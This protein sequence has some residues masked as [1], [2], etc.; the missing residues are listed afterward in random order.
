MSFIFGRKSYFFLF[1]YVL[2]FARHALSW[3]GVEHL[4]RR[5]AAFLWV[6]VSISSLALMLVHED[7]FFLCPPAIVLSMYGI[8]ER[9][10]RIMS[11]F[12]PLLYLLTLVALFGFLAVHRGNSEIVA[13]IWESIGP[14]SRKLASNN[15]QPGGGIVAL[16]WGLLKAMSLP[17]IVV[18]SGYAPYWMIPIV[19]SVLGAVTYS[20]LTSI[21]GSAGGARGLVV[22]ALLFVGALPL[23][24][25]GF[26]WGRWIA[27]TNLNRA[28]DPPALPGRQQ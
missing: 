20:S 6:C 17:L 18:A 19:V 28:G 26:D 24:L 12:A 10:D 2:A 8:C 27:A 23:F 3:L 22:Y 21:A 1:V 13:E 15:G 16:D 11:V 4:P 14:I 7:F 5:A 9:E 25:L